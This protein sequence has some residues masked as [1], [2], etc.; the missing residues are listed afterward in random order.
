MKRLALTA[1]A[2]LLLTLC[3]CSW[4]LPSQYTQIS[5]HSAAQTAH[6]DSDIPLVSD[7]QELKRAILQ[8]AED[9]VAHGVIRTANYTG[10]V[11]ADLSRAAYSAAREDPVGAYA[12]DFLTHDCSL[13]VSYYEITIDITFRDMAE[14]PRTLEY[15]TNQKEVETLLREAMDEYQDHVTWYAVSSHVYNYESLA[16]QI[17]EAEP[18]HYMAVP[19]IRTTNYPEEGRSRIVELTLTW[20]ADAATLQKMESAV[21]ESLQ[22][23]SVYVRYRDT[24]WEKA[25]LLYTYLMER[26]TYTERET[27]TPL[28]SALCEGLIT[29]QS[30]ANAW[31]LL[32]D[33]IGVDCQT[34]EGSR[35]GEEYAWNIVTL[36]G[37]RYHVDLLRDLLADGSLHLRYDEEMT[38]YSWD[39]AQ[40]PACPKPEPETPA[41]PQPEEPTDDQGGEETPSEDLP[42]D[43][44]PA[45]PVPAEPETNE[46]NTHE[47]AHRT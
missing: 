11:E 47:L 16:R 10:D 43:E 35:D 42:T 6:N 9:G 2:L 25:G 8:F 5:A 13:I 18:L 38:G 36:D 24:E 23:A 41:E 29:S 4:L 46:K 28:Y 33:Q 40:Y 15:V 7:Y 19:D 1:L 20:P 12:I 21:E 17:C 32:C 3:G 27:A 34:V 45:E 14:D 26:F 37:L 39:A 44:T 30:A 22:A 31:Q